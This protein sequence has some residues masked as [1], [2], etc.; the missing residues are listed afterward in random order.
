MKPRTLL[1]SVFLLVFISTSVYSD[2]YTREQIEN[3]F[4]SFT[5]IKATG[6]SLLFSGI[7]IDFPGL[8]F[9]AYGLNK[10]IKDDQYWDSDKISP[11]G[12]FQMVLGEV[13]LGVG[14]P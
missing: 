2:N 5:K 11:D 9:F 4:S 8:Y 13:G 3:K 12:Y 10:M 6:Y 7:G 1:F 14:S